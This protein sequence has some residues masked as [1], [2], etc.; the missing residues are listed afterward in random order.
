MTPKSVHD[1]RTQTLFQQ[2]AE[3]PP[4]RVLGSP[5]GFQGESSLTT[6]AA[7]RRLDQPTKTGDHHHPNLPILRQ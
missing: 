1:G 2:R 7:N 5:K 4:R 3:H 6:Q